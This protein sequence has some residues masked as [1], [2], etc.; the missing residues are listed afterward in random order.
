MRIIYFI[1]CDLAFMLLDNCLCHRKTNAVAAFEGAGFLSA[2]E[3][4]KQAAYL[5]LADSGI[6][7]FHR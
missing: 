5:K 1:C 7:I 2:V 6:S 3:P 4:V